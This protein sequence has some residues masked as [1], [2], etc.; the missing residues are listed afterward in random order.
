MA[1]LGAA[2]GRPKVQKLVVELG[3]WTHGLEQNYQHDDVRQDWLEARGFTVL[4][5]TDDEVMADRAAVGDTIFTVSKQ[6]QTDRRSRFPPLVWAALVRSPRKGGLSVAEPSRRG[7]YLLSNPPLMGDRSAGGRAR[8]AEPQ[9]WEQP[10]PGRSL[11][12]WRS[13]L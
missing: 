2:P 9:R 6:F 4:R 7:D 1:I 11:G 10:M 5:F 12:G 8:G 13:E 3:G